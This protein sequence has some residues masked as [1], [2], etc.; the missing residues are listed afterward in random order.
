M[1]DINFNMNDALPEHTILGDNVIIPS[2][3]V[4][5]TAMADG[6]KVVV[7]HGVFDPET[8]MF[9]G[10]LNENNETAERFRS[11]LDEPGRFISSYSVYATRMT[12]PHE[13]KMQI[14]RIVTS[15][16]LLSVSL[17][18]KANPEHGVYPITISRD[19]DDR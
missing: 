9:S 12:M 17:M 11:R 4:P 8:G 5:I 6:K 14:D 1:S 2:E 18:K 16:D 19:P 10:V 15:P 7:G 13:V 3:P